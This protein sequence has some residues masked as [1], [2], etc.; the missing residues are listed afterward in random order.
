[1]NLNKL[2]IRILSSS[3]AG[4]P[5][6]GGKNDK[7][8]KIPEGFTREFWESLSEEQ[9]KELMDLS[10]PIDDAD[11]PQIIDE[12][13]EPISREVEPRRTARDLGQLIVSDEHKQLAGALT[14][15]KREDGKLIIPS[16][17]KTV[18]QNFEDDEL[19][20][21]DKLL[22]ESNIQFGGNLEN[23]LYVT[24]NFARKRKPATQD[25]DFVILKPTNL[26]LIQKEAKG[27]II[28]DVI[29]ALD[30]LKKVHKNPVI[31]V[32]IQTAADIKKVGTDWIKTLMARSRIT[33][34]DF[35][36][37]GE[38]FEGKTYIDGGT[39]KRERHEGF[40]LLDVIK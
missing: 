22:K 6:G 21:L 5:V 37:K 39:G 1:M 3:D 26:N 4:G 31:A 13:K 20:Q 23:L 19:R 38:L 30:Q 18:L 15:Y 24:I 9:R 35:N 36:S 17:V 29:Y 12:A 32:E 14:V 7:S 10:A 27:L 11:R 40:G 25:K 28:D 2:N 16:T 34:K 8:Q 33:E